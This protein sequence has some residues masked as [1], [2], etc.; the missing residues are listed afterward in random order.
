YR[1][2]YFIDYDGSNTVY[3]IDPVPVPPMDLQLFNESSST[4]SNVQIWCNSLIVAIGERYWTVENELLGKA[5]LPLEKVDSRMKIEDEL[6]T[7][8]RKRADGG[9]DDGII[10]SIIAVK[11]PEAIE[12]RPEPENTPS[13]H[14][15]LD[16]SLPPSL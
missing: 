5:I 4:S 9:S 14:P 1:V 7:M 3:E 10:W 15:S 2:K 11:I 13:P 6:R 16:S 12:R 8:Y